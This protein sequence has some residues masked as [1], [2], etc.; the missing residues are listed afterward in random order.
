K[1]RTVASAY[2]VRPTPD[3]RVSMPLMWKDVRRCDPATFTIDTV[4]KRVAKS[5]DPLD[6]VDEAVGS[7]DPLL[8]LAKE[9]ESL[10]FGDAAWPPQFAKAEGEPRRVQPSKRKGRAKPK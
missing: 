7:L 8:E 10:G 5:G 9:H 3:A 4:P 6:G 2:S 1:D